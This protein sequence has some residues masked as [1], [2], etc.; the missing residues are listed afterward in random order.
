MY[1][2]TKKMLEDAK[3]ILCSVMAPNL[4][5]VTP[6]GQVG[7]ETVEPARAKLVEGGAKNNVFFVQEKD[8]GTWEYKV[9]VTPEATMPIQ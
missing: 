5:V 8:K 1:D 4:V 6:N 7:L 9:E 3:P 2:G